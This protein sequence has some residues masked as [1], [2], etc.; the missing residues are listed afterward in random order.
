MAEEAIPV[1]IETPKPETP[2]ANAWKFLPLL[3]LMQAIPVALVQE[4]API[5]FKDLGVPN[6]PITRWTSLIAIPW[7]LQLLLGPLVDLNFT[8][9]S[10]ILNTQIPITIVMAILPLLLGVPYAFEL[11]LGIMFLGAMMSALCNIATDG[12]VLLALKKEDQ[13]R[14]AGFMSTFYRLGRMFVV[15]LLVFLAGKFS[16]LHNEINLTAPS[17]TFFQL[18]DKSDFVFRD[19]LTLTVVQGQI[20][21]QDGLALEPPLNFSPTGTELLVTSTGEVRENGKA[22]GQIN[23][24]QLPSFAGKKEFRQKTAATALVAPPGPIGSGT[25]VAGSS[26]YGA[27]VKVMFVLAVLYGI[28]AFVNRRTVPK[29][30]MDE[31]KEDTKGQTRFNLMQTGSIIVFCLSAYFSANAIVRILADMAWRLRDGKPDGPLKGWMLVDH[32]HMAGIQIPLS[33]IASEFLQLALCLTLALVSWTFVRKLLSGTPMGDAYSSYLRQSGI[34]AILA[35]L[36]F[37][38]FGEAMVAKMSPLFLKDP[39][40]LGG[41]G[42]SNEQ[43][44]IVK[45]IIGVVGIVLGGIIGGRFVAK[46]GLKK[47]FWPLAIIMHV[48]NLLYLLAASVKLPMVM[49]GDS[50]NLTLGL[51]DFIDQ[52]GYGFGY[53][54][55][56]IFLMYIAQRGNFRTAH[57]AIGTGLGALFISVAGVLSGVLQAQFGYQGFFVWVIFLT[58]PGMISMLFLPYDDDAGKTAPAASS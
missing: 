49:L 35:F 23:V 27:W 2:Q 13:A 54:G 14:F 37:Y 52:F 30:A 29:P 55:Y 12:F 41:L 33:G 45:G 16:Q 28:G 57:Y 39:Q 50:V 53:S 4:L 47:A 22:I 32:P 36:L 46:V 11:S 48:P 26:R 56:M 6:E 5:V 8:K 34:W 42:I 31:F 20:G 43:V 15:G 19:E 17:G 24:A 21:S 9:R 38:R 18:K 3:Y 25:A 44:G 10:W 7:S 58:I 40:S 51:I 1:P